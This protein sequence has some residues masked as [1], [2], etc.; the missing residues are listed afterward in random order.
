MKKVFDFLHKKNKIIVCDD[1]ESIVEVIKI[2]LENEHY[3]VNTCDSEDSLF[4]CLETY[5]PNL[6]LLD[7]WMHESDGRHIVKKLKASEVTRNIPVVL[8]SALNEL[9]VFAKE[10]GADGYLKKPFEMHSL[11]AQIKELLEAKSSRA[12]A[13]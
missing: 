4:K 3:N 12:I 2:I 10:C 5:E 7:V 8:I 6:I 13:A 11:V 1:D 9:E